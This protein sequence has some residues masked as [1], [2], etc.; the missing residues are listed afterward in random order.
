M[1]LSAPFIRRPVGTTLLAI[2]LVLVG[3]AAY[4]RLPVASL[5]NVEFPA[6]FISASRPGADPAVMA[7]TVAAPLERA[8]GAISGVTELTSASSLG[9]TRIAVQF[10]LDRNIDDAARDVQAAL[11]AA[12][13]GPALRHPEPADLPK[14]QPIRLP[15]D[16]AGA[17]LGHAPARPKS[18]TRPT[19][20]WF[21]GSP[22]SRAS[23]RSA[24]RAPSSRRCA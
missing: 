20:C 15:R 5:P 8:L 24:S 10:D 14:D 2:G 22:R 9:S 1:S 3:L 16:G 6:I 18:M 13:G 12:F 4:V 19:A 7:S 11:N 17:D 21:S 23:E